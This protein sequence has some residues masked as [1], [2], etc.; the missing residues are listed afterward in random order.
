MKETIQPEQAYGRDQA[1]RVRVANGVDKALE[2]A[3]WLDME[4]N[5][6]DS[7]LGEQRYIIRDT[8]FGHACQGAKLTFF[9]KEG[10]RKDLK[11]FKPYDVTV[12]KMWLELAE[13]GNY[14][15]GI[16]L[17]LEEDQAYVIAHPLT[18]GELGDEEVILESNVGAIMREYYEPL[19]R[20][21]DDPT[22][23]AF[24]TQIDP[25]QQIG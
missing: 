25:Y 10:A 12:R 16:H 20:A 19:E 8:K 2:H 6:S 5:V 14:I 24:M 3:F 15:D 23:I 13:P 7:H 18:E 17:V 1:R 4:Q 9:D 22:S 11:V 21:F